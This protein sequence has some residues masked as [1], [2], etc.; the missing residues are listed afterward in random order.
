MAEFVQK[1]Q[2]VVERPVQYNQQLGRWYRRSPPVRARVV[3]VENGA[4]TL[5]II[6][7]P[8]DTLALHDFYLNW[9]LLL[10]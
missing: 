10:A 4:V 7:G 2:L 8:R 6:A 1:E 5:E 3:K 9:E